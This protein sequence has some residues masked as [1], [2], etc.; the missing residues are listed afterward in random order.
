MRAPSNRG[1]GDARR[2]RSS[3]PSLALH[4]QLAACCDR[5]EVTAMAMADDDGRPLALAGELGACREVADKLAR[6]ASRIRSAEYTA[7]APGHCYDVS[8]QRIHTGRGDVIVCAVGG[9]SDERRRHIDRS[10]AAA[11]RILAA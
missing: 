5:G 4:F 9:S 7:L 8:M 11:Q 10:A 6:V 1:D 2:R 3:D